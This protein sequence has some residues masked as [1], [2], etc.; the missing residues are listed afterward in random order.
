MK[1]HITII[2]KSL[3]IL[4]GLVFIISAISKII[5]T[6]SFGKVIS[7][8]TF[9]IFSILSPAIVIFELVLGLHII[10]F[11][12]VKRNLKIALVAFVIFT[13]VYSYG[14]FIKGIESCGCF[15]K[16]W[17]DILDKPII[18]FCRNTLLIIF[19]IIAYRYSISDHLDELKLKK[20]VIYSVTVI[21]LFLSGYTFHFPSEL[22]NYHKS[23]LINQS[24]DEIGLNKFYAY[25]AD[26]TYLTFIFSYNCFHCLNT[27]ANVNLYK[28]FNY[29]DQIIYISVGNEQNKMDFLNN[30]CIDGQ[31]IES[32]SEELRS[33]TTEYPTILFIKNKKVI[34]VNKGVISAP[35]VFFKKF[36]LNN[37]KL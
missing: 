8:Y 17:T 31:L 11:I 5:D 20:S 32:S 19:T 7:S 33:I 18:V 28:E 22:K 9:P 15:G 10:F 35:L 3:T 27:V 4:I 25:D 24:V 12:N 37:K 34:F 30:Y 6:A 14:Y 21:A 2:S 23:K 36:N 1:K 29:I 16:L 26:S 13:V